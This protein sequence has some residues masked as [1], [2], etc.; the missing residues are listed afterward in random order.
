MLVSSY[1]LGRYIESDPSLDSKIYFHNGPIATI[2][3]ITFDSE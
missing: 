3:S 1:I 2:N